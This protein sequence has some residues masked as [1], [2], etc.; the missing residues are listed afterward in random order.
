ML[1]CHHEADVRDYERVAGAMRAA[2]PDVVFHLAAQAIVRESYRCPRQTVETNVLGTTNV[3][4]AVRTLGRPCAVVV[5]TTDKCYENR[6]H[7]WGYREVDAMGGHDLYSASKGAAE[8]VTAA[9]R[10][11]F[12]PAK[13]LAR[14]GVKVA[15]A[16]AGNVIGGGDWSA[17][18][19]V[20]DIV[21]HLAAGAPVPVRNPRAVRPWQHVLEPLNGYLSLAAKMLTTQE[22]GW[23]D[24]WNFG[25]LPGGD[26]PV[27]RL[28]EMFIEAWG[29]GRWQDVSDAKELHEAA[30]LRLSIE[31]ALHKL[32]WRPR[33]DLAET[34]A[35]TARWYRAFAE[36]GA[37]GMRQQCL[38]DI[39]A[40]EAAG[41][42]G[43]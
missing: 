27:Q 25:P 15:S 16:R 10:R 6:E 8:I 13:G 9:Y 37:G 40:Y 12:F 38:A 36:T 14:H 4:E 39:E 22:A 33:W 11:S 26:A 1:A 19:I 3:L 24:A 17:D 41:E 30:V 28:V 20:P 43:R 34:V 5:V 18:R 21:R 35:R 31:K 23:C 2:S 32:G 7:V 29:S 42:V